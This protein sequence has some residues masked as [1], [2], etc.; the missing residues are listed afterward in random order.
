MTKPNIFITSTSGLRALIFG[1]AFAGVVAVSSI[2]LSELAAAG[3]GFNQCT[4]YSRQAAVSC[5]HQIYGNRLP[6]EL[7]RRNLTCEQAVIC[8]VGM[9][10]L[11][12]LAFPEKCSIQPLM[13]G[14][15]K[16]KGLKL[17]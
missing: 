17:S 14:N 11:T 3:E 16:G 10:P 12:K 9:F 5:C 6:F 4:S 7:R 2:S 13:K 1:S 8:K 15:D